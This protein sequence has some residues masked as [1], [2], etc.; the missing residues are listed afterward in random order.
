MAEPTLTELNNM[1]DVRAARLSMLERYYNGTQPLAY[2]SPE[3]KK[4]LGD[5]FGRLSVN[6]PRLAVRSIAERLR[7]TGFGGTD[8]AEAWKVWLAN[9]MD[10]QAPTAHR[11]ALALGASP[12]SVWAAGGRATIR[13]ESTH[14]TAVHQDAGT[15]QSI[16]AIKR[17]E[18]LAPDG[19]AK[20]TRWL[21]YYPDRIL[22]LEGDGASITA[23]KT[24]ET[25]DNPLGAV[26]IVQLVN[27]DRLLDRFGVSEMDD[28]IPLVDALNKLTADL[29]VGSE[30]SARPRRWATGLELEERPKLDANGDPVLD[31]DG[32]PVMEEVNPIDDSDRMAVNEAEGGKFGQFTGSDL[33]AYRNATDILTGQIGA[34]SSLPGHYLGVSKDN[35]SS[36]D[37]IRAAE[38]SLTARAEDKQAVFGRAWEQVARLA[39]AVTTDKDVAEFD[40]RARWS[41][42]ATRSQAQEADWAVKLHAEGL[43]TNEE[44]RE[45]LGINN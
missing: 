37:G 21:V 13:V 36:A 33:A 29:L 32:D 7:V 2:L 41:D 22:R 15:G 5:R 31:S 30:Y 1:L 4:A 12:V 9:D 38:A 3:A 11:E 6:I 42:P 16:A 10:Q 8:G 44:A 43:V 23:A 26:P 17:W 34:V 39:L 28:L 25:L 24:V 27:S 14:Q 40:V 18:D 20:Q 45:R 19:T 35:P